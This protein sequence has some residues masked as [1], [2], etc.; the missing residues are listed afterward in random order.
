MTSLRLALAS[1]V[2]SMA[3]S[4]LAAPSSAEWLLISSS[5][6]GTKAPLQVYM[7]K[8]SGRTGANDRGEPIVSAMSQDIINGISQLGQ[9]YVR[10][11][12]C[13][14]GFGKVVRTDITGNFRYDNEWSSGSG[15]V[16]T[17]TAG[18]LCMMLKLNP[19]ETKGAGII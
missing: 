9:I 13:E 6:D 5:I 7:K 1:A 4:A 17:G 16:A 18:V 10:V 19:T 15:T 14:R 12:D 8:G 2:V 11:S 3:T